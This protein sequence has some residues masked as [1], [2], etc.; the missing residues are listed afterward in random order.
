MTQGW[1]NLVFRT[2]LGDEQDAKFEDERMADCG[3]LCGCETPLA[4]SAV[5]SPMSEYVASVMS[6]MP[7]PSSYALFTK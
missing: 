3:A 5:F 2:L 1:Q 7:S 4:N 6:W